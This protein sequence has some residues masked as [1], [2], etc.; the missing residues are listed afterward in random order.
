MSW[1]VGWK[2]NNFLR[3]VWENNW[4]WKIVHLGTFWEK[5][6]KQEIKEVKGEV[7]FSYIIFFTDIVF[8]NWLFCIYIIFVNNIFVDSDFIAFI[9]HIWS[10]RGINVDNKYT[11]IRIFYQLFV[12][13]IRPHRFSYLYVLGV[14]LSQHFY[15]N[16]VEYLLC[17]KRIIGAVTFFE[18]K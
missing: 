17:F 14:A 13:D 9:I 2:E 3:S 5:A 10:H 1:V 4:F 16:P 8:Y 6:L 11:T 15:N 18:P 12:Y 7:I